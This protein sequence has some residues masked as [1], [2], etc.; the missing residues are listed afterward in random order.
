M[1][2]SPPGSS[3]HGIFQVRILEW[4]AISFSRRSSNPG[5]EPGSPPLQADSLPSELPGKPN[6]RMSS[7]WLAH[8]TWKGAIP[9]YAFQSGT[10]ADDWNLSL[11]T[12]WCP[13]VS[14][15]WLASASQTSQSAGSRAESLL[16]PQSS[17]WEDTCER[18]SL[19]H[20]LWSARPS[21]SWLFHSGD[22]AL[23]ASYV[24][25]VWSPCFTNVCSHQNDSIFATAGWEQ[26]ETQAEFMNCLCR[27]LRVGTT[28]DLL[29][30]VTFT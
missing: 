9:T 17:S 30:V 11:F 22:D 21:S 3:V 26:E 29:I 2:C 12:G 20:A 25:G 8:T 5:M 24:L 18:L 23:P 6:K 16:G 19:S 4:G 10:V 27:S 13:H 7:P 28:R 14:R 1:D 15:G